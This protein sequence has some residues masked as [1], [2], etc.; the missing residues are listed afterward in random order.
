MKPIRIVIALLAALALAGQAHA[1]AKQIA[2]VPFKIN[3]DKDVGFLRDGIYDMLSSRLYKEGEVEVIGRPQVEKTIASV[4]G[5]FT[6]AK[7]RDIGKLMGAD[8]LLYG[9]LT[10][11]GN[12][13]SVDSKMVDVS[14]AK[15]VL[16]FFEQSEDAGGIVTR[17]NQMAAEIN[18]K[19][20]GRA[21]AARAAAPTAAAQ[22]SAAQPADSTAHPEKMF[23]QQ[24]GVVGEG[25]ESPF[26][27]DESAGREFS[28]QIWR[29]PTITQ[30]LNGLALGDVDRDGKVETVLITPQAVMIYRYDQKR[31]FKVAEIENSGINIGVDVADINGNGIP[32]IFVTSLTLSRKG[33]ATFVLEWDGKGFKRIVEGA[34]WFYRVSATP[35]RGKVLLGQEHRSE[36]PFNGR[37]YEMTWRGGQYEPDVELLPANREV[38]VL[39]VTLSGIVEGQR[40][41]VVALDTMDH[42]K[43]FEGAGKE[44]WK[45]TERYGGS[46]LYYSGKKTDM[47]DAEQPL[48]FTTRLIPMESKDGKP[49]ILTVKNHDIMG[50]I[51]LEKFRAFNDSQIM[52]LYWDGMGLAQEWRTRKL[53]G[54]IRDFALGDFNNDGKDEL[55]AAVVLEEGRVMGSTPRC[56]VI[57]LEFK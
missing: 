29:S 12:S 45:S 23:K 7:A 57:A 5:G 8:Y 9:S 44:L 48:Y 55:V 28:P 49:R 36:A 24:G 42:I 51:R 30:V 39:G 25:R 38:S 15:P 18:D 10:V 21:P 19:M 37:V 20:F 17:V 33:L 34:N 26:A 3:A 16:S 6:E 35:D 14:G 32:E 53:T 47:G 50:A 52:A 54:C 31:F 56:T 27:T 22:G 1:A 41:T 40:E 43:V 2:I 46:T 13:I 4:A 11:L